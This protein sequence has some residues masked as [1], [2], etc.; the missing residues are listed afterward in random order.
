M[1]KDLNLSNLKPAQGKQS[2]K[3]VGRG[4]GSGK[5]RYSGR[6]I[7]G[8]KAR[9]G[10][11]KLRAGFEGGQMPLYMR[12]GK[13][14]GSTSKD[15]MPVGPFRTRTYHVNLRDLDAR[16]DDGAE[17]TPE[18]LAEKGLIRN[19]RFDVKVL[20]T[21]E[22]SK[23]L[24]ITVHRASAAAREKIEAAGGSLSLLREPVEKKKRRPKKAR[25]QAEAEAPEAAEAEPETETSEAEPE[26]EG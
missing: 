3:R 12:V 13:Q 26:A 22:L 11:H 2:P 24:T 7:K 8:Q 10:S 18:A 17:V 4:L 14:R 21:G 9:A 23:K 15:A 19:T 25:P 1:P 20:A 6:G 5:G 16:F